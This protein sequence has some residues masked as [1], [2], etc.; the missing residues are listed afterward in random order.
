MADSKIS[1]LSSLAGSGVDRA[2]DVL[3]IVDTG[4]TETKKITVVELG[5]ALFTISA[6]QA[7]TSGTSI[8]FTS[9]PAGAKRI[10]VMFNGV[11][12][13]GTSDLLIQIG[14]S[15]GVENTGYLGSG[16]AL[17]DSSAVGVTSSTA[18]F[19]I[20]TL[21]ATDVIS[22]SVVLTLENSAAFTWTCM[23]V[24][25]ET[26]TPATYLTSGRKST[27]AALDRVRVTTVNGTDTFDAGAISISYE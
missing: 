3:P 15:G 11:S 16:V 7:S 9:I 25:S 6:E 5:N 18:G 23:G 8:D 1:A 22:G 21:A 13:S 12:T 2:T 10:T 20:R 14:D 24:L 17:A 4:S 19:L 26:T 27:S